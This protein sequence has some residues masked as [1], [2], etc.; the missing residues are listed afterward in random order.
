MP[1]GHGHLSRHWGAVGVVYLN[2]NKAFD[3]LLEDKDTELETRELSRRI[4]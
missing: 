3:S 2:F 4:R 1:E